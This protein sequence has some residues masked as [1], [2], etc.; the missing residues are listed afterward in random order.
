MPGADVSQAKE[1]AEGIRKSIEVTCFGTI[2]YG[3]TYRLTVSILRLFRNM[4]PEKPW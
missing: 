4:E 2:V 1:K 3:Q